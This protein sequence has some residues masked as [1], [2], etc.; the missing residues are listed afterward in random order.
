MLLGESVRELDGYTINDTAISAFMNI[1]R[2]SPSSQVI[3]GNENLVLK[4]LSCMTFTCQFPWRVDSNLCSRA[5]TQSLRSYNDA[6]R[7]ILNL[8]ADQFKEWTC[9][10]N[11]Y[12]ESD[13][14]LEGRVEITLREYKDCQDL[15]FLLPME[16]G[17]IIANLY[18][19]DPSQLYVGM[20]V[21][22]EDSQRCVFDLRDKICNPQ[23]SMSGYSEVESRANEGSTL[24][25]LARSIMEPKKPAKPQT[26]LQESF[27]QIEKSA[28]ELVDQVQDLRGSLISN[29]K[30]MAENRE[31]Q[32]FQQSG[33]FDQ[34]H[35]QLEAIKE[36][37]EEC[38]EALKT[39]VS[40]ALECLG[41]EDKQHSLPLEIDA[42]K[43]LS[44]EEYEL[45]IANT[46]T[47]SFSDLE[48]LTMDGDR[49]IYLGYIAKILPVS[50]KTVSFH[51]PVATF[52]RQGLISPFI[53]CGSSPVSSSVAFGLCSIFD[54]EKS[55]EALEIKIRNNTDAFIAPTLILAA[56]NK[57][58][59][60]EQAI[61]PGKYIKINIPN[62]EL[63]ETHSIYAK[64]NEK[65]VSIVLP[66]K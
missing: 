8:A 11:A 47:E 49:P 66:L 28:E 53:Q 37:L 62:E 18:S 64:L 19:I 45:T 4:L 33:N 61:Q 42:I 59:A 27:K 25:R 14:D 23:I 29:I 34:V 9:T 43:H 36:Q 56:H 22:N 1:V 63:E 10:P 54:L 12:P 52:L 40:T 31:T 26:G 2:P 6:K 3:A 24:L 55:D 35:G 50:R 57:D 20:W 60:S 32:V 38:T 21:F 65:A 44:K 16:V 7:I 41:D 13:E 48:I 58:A 39:T 15:W 30:E 17:R 51:I 46:S 5:T